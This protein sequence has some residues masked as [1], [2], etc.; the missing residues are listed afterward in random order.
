MIDTELSGTQVEIMFRQK[1]S[2]LL[3]LSLVVVCLFTIAG[4][5]GCVSEPSAPAFHIADLVIS[6]VEV[7]PEGVVTISAEVTNTGDTEGSYTAELKINGVIEA[8]QEITL[9]GGESQLL[10]FSVSRDTLGTYRV[11]WGE[12]VGEFVVAELV[13]PESTVRTMVWTDAAITQLVAGTLPGAEAHFLPDNRVRLKYTFIT[14]T[15]D[16]SVAD[17]QLCL[18]GVPS[19]V[20]RYLSDVIGGYTSYH[21]GKLFLT[22]L[23]SWFDPTEEIA[24]DVTQLPTLESIETREGEAVITYRWP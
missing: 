19:W 7:E 9:V 3:G 22:A 21:D 11:T 1:S 16:C 20:A 8:A 14:L 15:F 4:V 10:S 18:G 12:L 24:P 23:P 13:P 17:G 6:P 2:L 5:V